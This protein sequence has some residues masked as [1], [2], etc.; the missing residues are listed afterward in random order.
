MAEKRCLTDLPLPAAVLPIYD[1]LPP[2]SQLP[3]T[4]PV[5]TCF[6][7]SAVP[8]RLPTRNQ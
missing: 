5:C 8:I 2:P 4:L 1:G 6:E 3:A 7:S